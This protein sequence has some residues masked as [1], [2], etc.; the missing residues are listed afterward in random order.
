MDVLLAGNEIWVEF[1]GEHLLNDTLE[2]VDGLGDSPVRLLDARF[3]VA[4]DD[5]GG[6]LVRRQELPENAFIPLQKLKRMANSYA[7][8]RIICIS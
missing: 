5:A 2:V 8:L 1:G 6:V 3:L 4:L 7:A